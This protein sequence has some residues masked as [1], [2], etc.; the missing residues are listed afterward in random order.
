MKYWIVD[1]VARTIEVHTL[2]QSGLELR[3][4][5]AGEDMVESP[6]LSNLELAT[7]SIFPPP[8]G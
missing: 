3:G 5:F 2:V 4:S 6:L 7:E 8:L 1:P